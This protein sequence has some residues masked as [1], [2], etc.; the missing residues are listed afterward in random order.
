MSSGSLRPC[1]GVSPRPSRTPSSTRGQGTSVRFLIRKA[2]ITA[3]G[4]GWARGS[5]FDTRVGRVCRLLGIQE[6]CGASYRS[7]VHLEDI[8]HSVGHSSTDT[9]ELAHRKEPH[10]VIV[11]GTDVMG[12]LFAE[13]TT[14]HPFGNPAAQEE[15]RPVTGTAFWWSRLSESN[16]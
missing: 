2:V 16:R 5:V 11:E 12:T 14:G 8:A 13:Q 7:G 10:P 9:T 6:E 1:R 3:H 15:R 4:E